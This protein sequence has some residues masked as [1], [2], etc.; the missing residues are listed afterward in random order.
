MR[1]CFDYWCSSTLMKTRSLYRRQLY[2]HVSSAQIGDDMGRVL[3]QRI[4]QR[5]STADQVW[6]A[7]RAMFCMTYE[8]VEISPFSRQEGNSGCTKWIALWRTYLGNASARAPSLKTFT[9]TVN[10]S[11]LLDGVAD[12]KGSMLHRCALQRVRTRLWFC[13]REAR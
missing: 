5:L 3:Q 13:V 7:D 11:L 8:L 2:Y 6:S 9:L 10:N 4:W 1:I 12:W